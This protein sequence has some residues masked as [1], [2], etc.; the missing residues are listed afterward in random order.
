M[1]LSRTE[2][3]LTGT[4]AD[5]PTP[6]A[7]RP[8]NPAPASAAVVQT[9]AAT[10]HTSAPSL[11]A[12]VTNAA[13]LA[14]ELGA[15]MRMAVREGGRELVVSMRPAELGHLTVRVTMI[16]GL[17]TAQIAADRPEAARLLQQAL[18]QLGAVLQGLGYAVD[19]LD[20]SYAGAHG[21]S[22]NDAGGPGERPAAGGGPHDDDS[23]GA[24]RAA[25]PL[26]GAAATAS[27]DG[28]HLD[29]LA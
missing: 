29:L 1:A 3:P 8:D 22:G 13:E 9:P 17:L 23:P 24:D 6:A 5:A 7:A 2:P 26:T 20:V 27:G 19:T 28:D 14:H 25:T 11:P 15:R 10:A 18:P 16:D 12:P 21:G 4:P